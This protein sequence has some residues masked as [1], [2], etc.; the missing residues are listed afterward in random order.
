MTGKNRKAAKGGGSAERIRFDLGLTSIAALLV[1]VG[2]AG[3]VAVIIREHAEPGDLV[4]HPVHLFLA[5]TRP[6]PD[7]REKPALDGSDDAAVYGDR[8]P[9]DPL[10]DDPHSTVTDLAR[11]RGWSTSLPR[12]TAMWYASS[13]KGMTL[14]IGVSGSIV[15][16]M[17][18]R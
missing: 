16:G 11:L 13:C 15:S 1:A 7:E 3:L 8:C 14:R 17:V 4:R 12:A 18:M 9:G 6:K 5:I 2:P 10:E